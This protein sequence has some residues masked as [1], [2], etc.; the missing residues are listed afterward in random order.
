[1]TPK[2]SVRH[3]TAN[4]GKRSE[5]KTLFWAWGPVAVGNA[6]M[7]HFNGG[8]ADWAGLVLGGVG[9]AALPYSLLLGLRTTSGVVA[10]I[11]ILAF[12]LA[13]GGSFAYFAA[14]SGPWH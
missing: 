11:V 2:E 13:G 7:R 6:V 12:H 4:G 10:R 1:M 5:P 3:G 8:A 9:A 14:T